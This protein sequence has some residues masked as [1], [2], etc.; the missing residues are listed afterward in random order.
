[1]KQ[2]SIIKQNIMD[3]L[4]RIEMIVMNEWLYIE[5]EDIYMKWNE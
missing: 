3:I 2:L 4:K 1:M 5:V